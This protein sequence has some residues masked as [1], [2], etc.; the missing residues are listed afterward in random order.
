M[1]SQT[2][3]IHFFPQKSPIKG[4]YCTKENKGT[5]YDPILQAF[6]IKLSHI[7]QN[8]IPNREL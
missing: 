6:S 1:Q 4:F 2:L 8:G 5:D 7:T 3:N